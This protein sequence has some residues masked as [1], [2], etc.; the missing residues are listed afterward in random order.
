MRQWIRES[1]CLIG[2]H[3]WEKETLIEPVDLITKPD[4]TNFEAHMCVEI[5]TKTCMHCCCRQEKI[6]LVW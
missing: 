4:S 6:S 5:Q 3:Q 2:V 1:L